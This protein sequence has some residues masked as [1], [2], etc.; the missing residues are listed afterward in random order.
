LAPAVLRALRHELAEK[1]VAWVSQCWHAA[2]LHD[3]G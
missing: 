3:G 2:L 1:F